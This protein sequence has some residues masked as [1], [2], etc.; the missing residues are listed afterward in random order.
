MATIAPSLSNGIKPFRFLD[1]SPE[2]RN[3]IYELVL[4]FD[5]PINLTPTENIYQMHRDSHMY[6][7]ASDKHDELPNLS[8][9]VA[10]RKHITWCVDR[11]TNVQRKLD[12]VPR[13]VLSLRHVCKQID[14]EMRYMFFALNEFQFRHA[15]LAQGAF[16]R[17][18][19]TKAMAA[20]EVMGFRYHGDN[21]P[22]L[23][24]ALAKACPNVRVLKVSIDVNK[25]VAISGPNKTLRRA[26]GMEAF[27]SYIAGLEKLET[28]EM[29][30]T[31]YVKEIVDGVETAVEVDIN[32]PR[33]IGSWLRAKIEMGKL[34]REM[35]GREVIERE[36]REK[37]KREKAIKE[38]RKEQRKKSQERRAERERERLRLETERV[39]RE[40]QEIR[41]LDRQR[42]KREREERERQERERQERERQ[43]WGRQ[44]REMQERAME[45][46]RVRRREGEKM[47]RERRER[48]TGWMSPTLGFDWL[49][50]L[51]PEAE[52]F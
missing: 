41:R 28:F 49:S 45:R 3:K 24:P 38:K 7:C 30:G 25:Y 26:R 13:S 1:L 10:D 11:F 8:G 18:T 34:H 46:V 27:A 52:G 19:H 37:E 31:D 32:H 36:N 4:R 47:G 51:G 23:Y 5:R 39:E 44:E 14:E 17:M 50:G 15:G 20:I 29:V 22:K 6:S 35:V 21:A 40:R 43:E 2:L 12:D 16:E 42:R 48:T 9:S 33:A